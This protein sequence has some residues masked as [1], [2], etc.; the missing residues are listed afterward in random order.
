MAYHNYLMQTGAKLAVK[1]GS[2]TTPFRNLNATFSD[3]PIPGC[4]QFEF[5]SDPYW[6]CYVRHFRYL[7]WRKIYLRISDKY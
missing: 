4:E 6:E 3:I 7:L 1:I 2:E 5:K